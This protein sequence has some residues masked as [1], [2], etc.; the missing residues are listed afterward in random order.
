MNFTERIN[1]LMG[2]EEFEKLILGDFQYSTEYL[3]VKKSRRL[4]VKGVTG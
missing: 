2:I 4:A 1:I 3:D